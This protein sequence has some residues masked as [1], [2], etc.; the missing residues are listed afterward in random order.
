MGWGTKYTLIYDLFNGDSHIHW[1]W[2][3]HYFQTN[4]GCGCGWWL[5]AGKKSPQTHS[6]H[7]NV[8]Y[9]LFW[10]GKTMRI[11]FALTS[12]HWVFQSFLGVSVENG[13]KKNTHKISPKSNSLQC[14]LTRVIRCYKYHKPW[15]IGV[16]FTNLAIANGGYVEKYDIYHL[17][18]GFNLP[19]WKIYEWWSES[20]LGWLIIPNWME[21]HNPAMFQT[22]NQIGYWLLLWTLL[23]NKINEIYK[24]NLS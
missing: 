23:I 2:W 13:T 4:P 5:V 22:T 7:G 1:N 11:P 21:S 14:P 24:E 3:M 17:V 6:R 12:T 20:H 9:M 10:W 15:L 18:G 16:M 19:L 8:V